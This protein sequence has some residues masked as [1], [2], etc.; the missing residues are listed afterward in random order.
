MREGIRTR[1]AYGA[2][3][4]RATKAI[5]CAMMEAEQRGGSPAREAL[6]VEHVMPQKL[7]DEWRKELGEEAERIHGWYRD[8]LANLTLTGVNAELGAKSFGEKRQIIGLRSGVL[9]TRRIA[10]E[11][12]WNEAALER[13]G[14]DLAD[15]VLDLWPWS[16]PDAP[17]TR[18]P[19]GE[20]RMRWRITG[21]EWQEEEAASQ[22]VL[23]VAGELLNR[24]PKNADRLRGDALSTNLQLASQYPPDRKV[25]A[26]LMR[27]VPGHESYVM[28]PYGRDYSSS[29]ARCRGMGNRCELPVTVEVRSASVDS[30]AFWTLL[31][32]ETGGLPGQSDSWRS[33]SRWT[34]EINGAR[35]RIGIGLGISRIGL[36]L[37]ASEYTGHAT[38]RRENACAFPPDP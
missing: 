36:Y 33:W 12:A 23:N 1:K 15:R 22:M 37:R 8:R 30:K 20:S 14:E 17:T 26:L 10:E 28:Y 27:A 3:A 5:L 29:A 34:T 19:I 18:T 11:D 13:R 25:G 4:T 35:D 32:E 38:P 9:L 16:D 31:G 6:T 7:T 24:D 21:G 2:S